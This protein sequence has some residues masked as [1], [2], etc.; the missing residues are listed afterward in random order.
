M[1][2]TSPA[3]NFVF[4]PGGTIQ[5]SAN[6]ADS[7]GTVSKVEFFQGTVK[8]GEDTSAPYSYSWINVPAGIHGLSARATDNG[9]AI[10]N[11]SVVSITGNQPPVVTLTSPTNNAD[12]GAGSTVALSANASD[13]NGT[14][15]KVEFFRNTLKL[16]E[17]TTA[18]YTCLWNSF[19]GGAY[20]LTARATDN[21]GAITT[22]SRG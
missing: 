9:G 10:T 16:G 18:P 20:Q 3:N 15:S 1:S 11:S 8:L 19:P 13:S 21:G 22:S 4:T 6:A 12:F 14:V 7:D 5:I 2:V 17:D